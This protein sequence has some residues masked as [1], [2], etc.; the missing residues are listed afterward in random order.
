VTLFEHAYNYHFDELQKYVIDGGDINICDTDGCSLLYQFI[1]EYLNYGDV[2]SEFERQLC[3]SHDDSDCDFWDS[4]VFEWQLTPLENRK[5]NIYHQ[6]EFLFAYGA[7]PN[8]CIWKN[9][10]RETPLMMAVCNQDFYL[11]KYLLEHGAD[12]GLWLFQPDDCDDLRLG[13]EYWLMDEMDI[14]IINGSKGKQADIILSIAHL[15]WKHGLNG[16]WSG[17]CIN[18]DPEKGVIGSH[19]MRMLY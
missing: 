16:D 9:D 12:P 18:I 14:A 1:V 7:D 8:L 10:M 17:Y 2:P 13:K 4:Y 19:P 6:L 11:T 5:S 3:D 15:L